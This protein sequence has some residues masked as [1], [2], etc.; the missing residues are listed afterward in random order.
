MLKS[1]C[2]PLALQATANCGSQ[3]SPDLRDRRA[4][5]HSA[6]NAT[7][8]SATWQAHLAVKEKSM[9]SVTSPGLVVVETYS[10][11]QPKLQAFVSPLNQNTVRVS[12]SITASVM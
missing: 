2:R 7:S 9:A 11:K 4:N 5:L 10:G 1:R 6:N 12:W 8:I 3:T